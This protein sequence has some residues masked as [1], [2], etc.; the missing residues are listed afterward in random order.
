MHG[1]VI[2]EV[3]PDVMQAEP[4]TT[5]GLRY[6]LE[7]S[8]EVSEG[9]A[10]RFLEVVAGTRFA[11]GRI[12][13]E[14]QYARGVRPDLAI[15]G[16]KNGDP[17]IFVENKFWADLTDFQPVDY[18][19]ALPNRE[20]SVLAFIAPEGRIPDLWSELKERCQRAR[21]SVSQESETT[22]PCHVRVGVRTLRLTSWRRVFEELQRAAAEDGQSAIEQD[23]IQ[24]RGLTERRGLD[25]SGA[26]SPDERQDAA[27]AESDAT[28]PPLRVDE[29]RDAR[30]AARLLNYCGL[31]DE[32]TGRL[33]ADRDWTTQ[34]LRASGFGR[35][36]HAHDRLEL[37]LGVRFTLWRDSAITPLWCT[38]FGLEGRL[39][40]VQKCFDGARDEERALH[41]PIR[42]ATGVE[43]G[44]VIDHA[45]EQMRAIANRLLEVSLVGE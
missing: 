6:I 37:Y 10:G 28:F 8:L 30:A 45:A 22:D 21:L 36:L 11:I 13:S 31:I 26:A 19:K 23:I 17:R 29:P 4:A 1:S 25:G 38:C 9:I 3:I 18:L 14:W 2:G 44:R 39:P 35:H 7:A 32:I 41:I 5:Q 27:V 16:E 12:G 33:V 24:L 34:G 42:L 43:R 20:T 15:H 40:E